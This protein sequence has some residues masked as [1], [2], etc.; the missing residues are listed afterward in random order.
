MS[1]PMLKQR[2]ITSQKDFRDLCESFLTSLVSLFKEDVTDKPIMELAMLIEEELYKKVLYDCPPDDIHRDTLWKAIKTTSHYA[3]K[4]DTILQNLTEKSPT[5]NM[6]EVLDKFQHD[7]KALLGYLMNDIKLVKDVLN[8]TAAVNKKRPLIPNVKKEKSSLKPR[9]SLSLKLSLPSS[10]PRDFQLQPQQQHSTTSKQSN[11]ERLPSNVSNDDDYY[12]DTSV[13]ADP[14]DY[15][16]NDQFDANAG[17]W[18]IQRDVLENS[19][20]QQSGLGWGDA[21]SEKQ[22]QR[23]QEYIKTQEKDKIARDLQRDRESGVEALKMEAQQQ[24]KTEEEK[25]ADIEAKK[26]A[27]READRIRR[28]EEAA[29]SVNLN[30][31]LDAL[32]S[33]LHD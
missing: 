14:E 32:D 15:T 4:A 23:E 3:N 11:L 27:E 9:P 1:L 31:G 21:V 17:S 29:A 12:Y 16:A 13:A 8:P 19:V 2:R 30:S 22:R 24:K 33:F 10:L 25:L 28:E 18:N 20:N 26:I 6:N 5:V 7:G